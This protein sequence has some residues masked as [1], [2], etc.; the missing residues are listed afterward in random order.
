[1]ITER[2]EVVLAVRGVDPGKGKLDL[3][4]GFCELNET[5]EEAAARELKEELGLGTDDFGPLQYVM[6]VSGPYKFGGETNTA[7]GVCF[8]AKLRPGAKITIGDDVAGTVTL[9][10]R[11]IDYEKVASEGERAVLRRL[12]ELGVI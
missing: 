8:W 9:A 10:A 11:D 6:S 5:L 1:M 12:I 3:A 2:Q 7:L 4:G